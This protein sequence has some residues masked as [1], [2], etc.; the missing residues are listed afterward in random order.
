MTKTKDL[1]RD[2]QDSITKIQAAARDILF[3]KGLDASLT[4][5][6]RE[7]GV[8]VG[9]LYHRFGSREGLIDA[10]VADIASSRLQDLRAV[11][12]TKSTARERLEA[13]IDGMIDIQ[14]NNPA[15]ND[16]ILQR[17]PNAV[18]LRSACDSSVS[19]GQELV[20]DAHSEGSLSPGFTEDDLLRLLWLAGIAN[21]DPAAPEGW[22][23]ILDRALESAWL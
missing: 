2:A 18:T 3:N 19:L 11:V 9:T 22:Q 5:I 7:A 8:S 12:M 10:V 15:L 14:H 21:R 23:R 16:A 17:Y 6:A 4:E 20:R 1:R 13:F